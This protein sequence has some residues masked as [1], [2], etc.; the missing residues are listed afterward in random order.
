MRSFKEQLAHKGVES[1]KEWFEKNNSEPFSLLLRVIY[2]PSD[3]HDVTKQTRYWALFV[4]W[5]NGNMVEIRFLRAEG[6][7]EPITLKYIRE[8]HVIHG[9]PMI[10]NEPI[11]AV[12]AEFAQAEEYYDQSFK[13][14]SLEKDEW[15]KNGKRGKKPQNPSRSH[16]IFEYLMRGDIAILEKN[17]H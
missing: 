5:N 3:P 13:Q 4:P 9:F 2:D 14:Y 6:I 16:K 17:R 11:D 8:N 1:L 7:S 10:V 12:E 15:E